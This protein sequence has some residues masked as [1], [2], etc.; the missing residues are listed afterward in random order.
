MVG[1]NL[2]ERGGMSK[3]KVLHHITVVI[4]DG[5]GIIKK[6]NEFSRSEVDI[7]AENENYLVLNN[8]NFSTISKKKKSLPF[9]PELEGQSISIDVNDTVWGSRVSYSLYTYKNTRA[10]TVRNQIEKF[11]KE[12]Y[13]FFINGINLDIISD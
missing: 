6:E 10:L 4:S 7:L 5:K 1:G 8:D 13:G 2:N 9:Y 3:E 11:I 12:K